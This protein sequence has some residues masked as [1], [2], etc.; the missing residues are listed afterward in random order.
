MKYYAFFLKYIPD[1]KDIEQ[2]KILCPFHDDA[3]PSLSVNLE[4]GYWKCFGCDKS[5]DIFTFYMLWHKCDFKTAK[6]AILGDVRTPVLSE[7]EVAEAHKTLL[8]MQR[9]ITAIGFNRGWTLNT[10]IKFQLGWSRKEKRIFIPIRDEHGTLKNIRKYDMFHTSKNKFIGIKGFNSPYFFPISNLINEK[11]KFITLFAG[12]PDTILACQLNMVAGT[13]TGGEGTFNRNLLPLF[14][15]KVV[16]VCY[17]KDVKGYRG[18]KAIGAE[19][20]KHAKEVKIIN[21][22]F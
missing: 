6:Y 19:V 1:L 18:T 12:E 7:G 3:E 14:K 17:D 15:D 21:L 2:Q 4:K 20:M 8:N 5:G 9:I 11:H 10:I 16:Y 22:P 13:F